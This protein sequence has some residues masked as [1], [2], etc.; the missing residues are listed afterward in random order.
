MVIH[1]PWYRTP[2]PWEYIFIIC[3]R[4]WEAILHPWYTLIT[5]WES[6]TWICVFP[7]VTFANHGINQSHH[8]T[9]HVPVFPVPWV[10]ILPPWAMF[11]SL[12]PPYC[13][14]PWEAHGLKTIPPWDF[15][16][17]PHSPYGLGPW[18]SDDK[19]REDHGI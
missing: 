13:I 5:P 12:W 18:D 8:G 14:G 7:W 4:P 17:S 9:D 19:T 16:F 11:T 1:C 2:L 15:C 10:F 3:V 6:H